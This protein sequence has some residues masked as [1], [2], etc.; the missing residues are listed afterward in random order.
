M[1]SCFQSS[2][3]RE[4]EQAKG[5]WAL[6]RTQPQGPHIITFIQLFF[7]LFVCLFGTVSQAHTDLGEEK[8]RLNLLMESSEILQW[9]SDHFWKIHFIHMICCLHYQQLRCLATP[10][11]RPMLDERNLMAKSIGSGL[12]WPLSMYLI[13][14]AWINRPGFSPSSITYWLWARVFSL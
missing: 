2:F 8:N 7:F 4:S 10:Q 12:R 14:N 3:S 9:K 6:Y 13:M 1:A 11:E 5:S